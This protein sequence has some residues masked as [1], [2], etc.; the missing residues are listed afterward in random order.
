MDFLKAEIAQKRKAVEDSRVEGPAAKYM[1][2]GEEDQIR[3]RRDREE[4]EKTLA[5]AE[6]KLE[7]L[8]RGVSPLSN[9]RGIPML[10]S[11]SLF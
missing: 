9:P 1:R 5:L 11:D 7:V 8:Q 6:A 3:I 4:K 2:R 10:N